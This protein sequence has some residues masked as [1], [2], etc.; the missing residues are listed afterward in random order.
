MDN[1]QNIFLMENKDIETI[2]IEIP[3]KLCCHCFSLMMFKQRMPQAANLPAITLSEAMLAR[4]G[5]KIVILHI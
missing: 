1:G 5:K 2:I 4:G 3:G